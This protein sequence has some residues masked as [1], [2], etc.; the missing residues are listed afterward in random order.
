MK[1]KSLQSRPSPPTLQ[2]QDSESEPEGSEQKGWYCQ[3]SQLYADGVLVPGQQWG[4]PDH[5]KTIYKRLFGKKSSQ[6]TIIDKKLSTTDSHNNA[7]TL[8]LQSDFHK[9]PTK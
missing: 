9:Y 6:A 2:A 8:V 3:Q 1:L 7:Y 5:Q 4:K